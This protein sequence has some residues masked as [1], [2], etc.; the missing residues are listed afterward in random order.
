MSSISAGTTTGTALVSTGDTTGNLDL[1]INGTTQ[2]VRVNT[3]GAIGVGTSPAFGTSGQV[4]TS[5]GSAAAPTWSDLPAPAG[6][7]QAVA[8]GSLA[9]GDTVIINSD[10][11]VSVVALS[12]LTDPVF[13]AAGTFLNA[14][15]NYVGS[16]YDSVN[17]KVVV[18]YRDRVT[19][20]GTA[21]VGTVVGTSI[22][23]GTPVV[24]SSSA[25]NYESVAYDVASGKIVIAYEDGNGRAIVGTVSGTSISFGT[26]AVFNAASTGE[27]AIAY[28]S[29]NS[30]VVITYQDGG[31]SSHG[32]AIVGTV[33]G[34]SISFG[35]EA[36]FNAASTESTAIV[37][38]S[39]KSKMVIAYR[40]NGNSNYG[41]AIVGTVSGTSISFGSEVV[42]ES[43][44]TGHVSVGYNSTE[45]KVVIAYQDEGNSNY[46]TAVVGT[47]SG[48]SISF[49]TPVVFR[50]APT[51]FT[52]TVYEPTANKMLISF[53]GWTGLSSNY[54][55]YFGATI[56]GTVSG[57]S[58]SFGTAVTFTTV[59][60]YMSSTYAGN[61]LV[62]SYRVGA[63][64]GSTF[65]GKS[66]VGS[67]LG[68]NMTT[69]NFIGFSNAA[70]TNGQTAT[71]QTVGSVDDAQ[72]SLTPG[73]AYYVQLDGSL[74][75]SPSSIS[76]F[77][78][79]AVAATKILVKG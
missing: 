60:Y 31:N 21:V 33:S 53:I 16:A 51:A 39:T 58:I 9:N 66:S 41:A 52:Q 1:K 47:V 8:T 37:Y 2:A 40:D 7:F 54:S 42:F 55:S 19:D 78:G 29:T 11:T 12:P 71:I 76:V 36:V 15:V 10:G 13:G 27:I 49:G 43:A 73:Q 4:L 77:A 46:G 69:E 22:T 45:G 20:Y 65:S 26:A 3:S 57:T 30:K 74:G 23:F 25:A 28:D 6:T 44:A 62:N 67:L 63:L 50:A 18:A 68:S 61:V 35:S 32:T 24:F 34:T 70:Y 17:G 59:P 75:L 48:T 5:A 56:V 64:D 79:T 14:N 72:S 38:D